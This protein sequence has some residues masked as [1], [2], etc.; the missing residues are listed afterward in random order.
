MK[1]KMEKKKRKIPINIGYQTH[2]QGKPCTIKFRILALSD[3]LLVLSHLNPNEQSKIFEEFVSKAWAH[4][5]NKVF[6]KPRGKYAGSIA[7]TS[8][9]RY[10]A[11]KTYIL[12]KGLLKN[13][14]DTKFVKK[15][16]AVFEEKNKRRLLDEDGRVRKGMPYEI[17]HFIMEGI[18]GEEKKKYPVLK[19]WDDRESFR[20]TYI[21]NVRRYQLRRY[22]GRVTP[23]GFLFKGFKPKMNKRGVGKDPLIT[24]RAEFHG[25]CPWV[26][27]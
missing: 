26:N 6:R 11:R 14:S 1:N 4:A 19:E 12:V 24:R 22:L 5:A 13:H 8:R 3:D 27:E 25:L 21:S 23:F 17:T 7:F 10:L 2:Y 16:N 9:M 18:F 15:L 20:R